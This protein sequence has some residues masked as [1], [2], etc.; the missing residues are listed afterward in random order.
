M[1]FTKMSEQF[2]FVLF[3]VIFS[4]TGASGGLLLLEAIREE[5]PNILY[6]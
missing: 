1:T 4:F 6:K 5:D 2:F 3:T